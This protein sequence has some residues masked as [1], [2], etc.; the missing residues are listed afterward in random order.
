[1]GFE[2]ISKPIKAQSIEEHE[3]MLED[4]MTAIKLEYVDRLFSGKIP[5]LEDKKEVSPDNLVSLLNRYTPVLRELMRCYVVQKE[6]EGIKWNPEMYDPVAEKFR[7]KIEELRETDHD[8]WIERTMQ[9]VEE[10]RGKIKKI[11]V[12]DSSATREGEDE[13]GGAENFAGIIN[14]NTEEVELNNQDWF[15]SSLGSIVK[16]GDTCISI[17]LEPLYKRTLQNGDVSVFFSR[18]LENLAVQIITKYPEARAVIANSWIIDT[19]IAKRIGLKVFAKEKYSNSLAFWGQFINDRGQ[20]DEVRVKKFLETGIAPFEVANGA[21]AVEDFLRKYLP[22]ENRGS[23]TLKETNPDFNLEEYEHDTGMLRDLG[24]KNWDNTD[25]VGLRNIFSQCP[26]MR[27][28]NESDFGR[29]FFDFLIR[30]KRE[31][32]TSKQLAEEFQASLFQKNFRKFT[33][34]LKY[35]DKKIVI[36]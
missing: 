31:Q 11:V 30:L 36:G 8:H 5:P 13:E 32:K 22:K 23:I 33:D 17:H 10:E 4:K 3:R 6:N 26:F 21:M 9:L 19:P 35:I 27:R 25:E 18:S 1:M 20:I 24:V 34:S 16:H 7:A 29:G 28:F 15:N 2:T 12:E 14:F